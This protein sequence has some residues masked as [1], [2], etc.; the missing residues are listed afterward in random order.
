[1][2]ACSCLSRLEVSPCSSTCFPWR[3]VWNDARH[4]R[5]LGAFFSTNTRSSLH[6][7][8]VR[9]LVV[10]AIR[11]SPWTCASTNNSLEGYENFMGPEWGTS[12]YYPFPLPYLSPNI[13]TRYLQRGST[14]V[15]ALPDLMTTAT[16]LIYCGKWASLIW[17]S[18]VLQS[19]N[20]SWRVL[21]RLRLA[22]RAPP[23]LSMASDV[24][25]TPARL[26]NGGWS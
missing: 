2:M 3:C 10:G 4:V 24:V 23:M 8:P 12:N 1:M 9:K 17:R 22:P 16:S 26:G 14:V 6:T 15:C 18:I 21:T 20:S 25:R 7:V 11:G 19:T 5:S 13:T